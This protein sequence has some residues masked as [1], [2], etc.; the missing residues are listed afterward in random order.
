MVEFICE[1]IYNINHGIISMLIFCLLCFDVLR[2]IGQ[3]EYTTRCVTL[4]SAETDY[5]R[6][7]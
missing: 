7:I 2:K 3:N 5:T 6:V 1:R 4:D